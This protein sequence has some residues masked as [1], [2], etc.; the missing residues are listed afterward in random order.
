MRSKGIFPS[1][2]FS[3]L[4]VNYLVLHF[5]QMWFLCTKVREEKVKEP[6]NLNYNNTD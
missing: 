1:K 5:W 6:A 2:Y 4:E 3:K